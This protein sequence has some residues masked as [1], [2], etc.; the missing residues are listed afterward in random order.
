M[1]EKR[2]TVC[3]EKA[4]NI[5]LKNQGKPLQRRQRWRMHALADFKSISEKRTHLRCTLHANF[6]IAKFWYLCEIDY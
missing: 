5:I 2:G 4:P 3:R 6:D 1:V